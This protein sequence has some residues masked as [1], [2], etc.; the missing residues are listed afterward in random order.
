[1][2]RTIIAGVV[3]LIVAILVL[4]YLFTNTNGSAVQTL[5]V[6]EPYGPNMTITL[7]QVTSAL[8]SS[9]SGPYNINVNYTA[10]GYNL[11]GKEASFEISTK[12]ALLQAYWV[13]FANAGS[14]QA[15][16]TSGS[17]ANSSSTQKGTVGNATYFY[18][19]EPSGNPKIYSAMYAYDGS[20]FI[21]I[22]SSQ[23]FNLTQGKQLLSDQLSE[24]QIS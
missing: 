1:M 3:V 21:A 9:W 24:L 7:Q 12:A 11:V 15:F 8:G 18:V 22:L 23:S 6:T 19:A 4:G 20:Y 5:N 10:N 2:E 17:Y 13:H 16:A 14:A